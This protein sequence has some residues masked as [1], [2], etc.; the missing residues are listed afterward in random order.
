MSGNESSKKLIVFKDAGCDGARREGEGP[1]RSGVPGV[2]LSF[3]DP[4]TIRGHFRMEDWDFGAGRGHGG[5]GGR[6][7]A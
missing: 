7:A 2:A 3:P 5:A 6:G 1:N 4:A